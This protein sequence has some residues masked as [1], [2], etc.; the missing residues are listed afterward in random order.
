[1]DGLH[2]YKG[3]DYDCIFD[4]FE[5]SKEHGVIMSLAFNNVDLL[6]VGFENGV[7]LT[8]KLGEYEYVPVKVV[9][10]IKFAESVT[11][12]SFVDEHVL[13]VGCASSSLQAVDCRDSLIMQRTVEFRDLGISAIVS[14]QDT[15]VSAGWDAKLRVFE[16]RSFKQKHIIQDHHYDTVSSLVFAKLAS[17]VPGLSLLHSVKEIIV[18]AGKD[19]IVNIWHFE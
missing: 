14:N 5:H 15:I 6:A 13:I 2:V 19:K 11:C 16:K 4:D 3:T 18:S 7:V 9:S 10:Q 17:P 12:L 1:M 8:Y